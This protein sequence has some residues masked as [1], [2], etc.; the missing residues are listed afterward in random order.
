MVM[1]GLNAA[2]FGNVNLAHSFKLP[3]VLSAFRNAGKGPAD[4]TRPVRGGDVMHGEA[5]RMGPLKHI[6]QNGRQSG[7]STHIVERIGE[8]DILCRQGQQGR[9]PTWHG[10]GEGRRPAFGNCMQVL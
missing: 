7:F 9:Q 2:V 3:G 10:G 8:V 5:G 6:F 1:M 4:V